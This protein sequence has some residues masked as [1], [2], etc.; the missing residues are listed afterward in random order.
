M[1]M[2]SKNRKKMKV[3]FPMGGKWYEISDGCIKIRGLQNTVCHSLID[4]ARAIIE[5]LN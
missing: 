5:S 4:S 2:T 3:V 1:A